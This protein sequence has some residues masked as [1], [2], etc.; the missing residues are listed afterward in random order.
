MVGFVYSTS[1]GSGINTGMFIC[2][3]EADVKRAL[4]GVMLCL[5]IL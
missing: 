5:L 3:H 2:F 4:G 1:Q